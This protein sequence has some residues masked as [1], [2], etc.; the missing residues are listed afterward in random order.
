MKENIMKINEIILVD[1]RQIID[2]LVDITGVVWKS[3]HRI[4]S[5]E[6]RM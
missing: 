3:F 5:E 2:E 1:R 4:L 6:S